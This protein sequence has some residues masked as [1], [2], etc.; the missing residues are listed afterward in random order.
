MKGLRRRLSAVGI[1]PKFLNEVVLPSW[2]D[3]GLAAEPGG[4]REAIG[5]IG[6][7]LGFSLNS[8]AGE[9]APAFSKAGAVK[10]KKQKGASLDDVSLATHL[11]LGVARAVAQAGLPACQSVPT[12]VKLREE[13]LRTSDQPWLTLKQILQEAWKLGIPV[14][15]VRNLPPGVKKPDALTTWLGDRPVIV[16]LKASK[17]PSWMA[18]I[19]SHELGHLHHQHVRPGQTII[20]EKIEGAVE[21][22]EEKEA[23]DF[24]AILLTGQTNLGLH[25]RH[26]LDIPSLAAAV[27]DF[28]RKFKV[29]PGVA[30]LNYGFTTQFWPVATGAVSQLEAK[31]NAGDE[32]RAAMHEHLPWTELP[33]EAREWILRTTTSLE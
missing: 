24:A 28:G 29:A 31:E 7:H 11:A 19:V 17:S 33:E 3:D 30:A 8:L 22:K 13:L 6:A 15:Q 9:Q 26:R 10:Y 21:E 27:I 16:V 12:P 23:N 20:D 32:I 4:F 5:Y 2:W 18:F 25:S 14:I 1:K